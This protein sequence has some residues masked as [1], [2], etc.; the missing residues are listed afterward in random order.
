VD[1]TG[2]AVNLENCAATYSGVAVE[3]CNNAKSMESIWVNFKLFGMLILSVIFLVGLGVYLSL[4]VKD[5]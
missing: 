3:L 2:Q 1:A 5:E 4:H